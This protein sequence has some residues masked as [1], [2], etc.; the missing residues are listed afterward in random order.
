MKILLLTD[1]IFPFVMGG[2]QKHSYYLAKYL[3]KEVVDV[4]LAHCV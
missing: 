4:T 2:M 3:D 1:G